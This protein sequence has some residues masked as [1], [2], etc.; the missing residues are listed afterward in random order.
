MLRALFR[1]I[2]VLIL[3]VGAAAFFMGYRYA[4][5]RVV[6]PNEQVPVGTTGRGEPAID[7]ST[8]RERGAEAGENLARAGNRAANAISDAALTPKITSKMALDDVVKARNIDV[9]T[10]DGTV[11]LS[12]DVH[13]EKE[14]ERAVALARE[15]E[16]V[17]NVVDR[18]RVLK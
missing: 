6:G 5:G 4:N 16:G 8:A 11:T 9:T 3:V 1:L 7:T 18:L 15:T 10:D 14:R 12:G 13:S 2:L 17:R